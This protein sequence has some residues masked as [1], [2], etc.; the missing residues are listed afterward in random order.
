MAQTAVRGAYADTAIPDEILNEAATWLMEL[1]E[2]PLSPG[3]R[4]HLVQWRQRSPEHERA[5]EKASVLLEKFGTLPPSGIQALKQT[6]LPERRKAVKVL[7]A[8]MLAPAAWITY[9]AVPWLSHEGR[10]DTAVGERLDIV[11]GDGSNVSLNTNTQIDVS[12]SNTERVV[13]LR[14]GEIMITTAKDQARSPRPFLVAVNEGKIRALGTRFTVRQ[15]ERSSQVAVFEGAVEIT[16]R[17]CPSAGTVMP[18]GKQSMFSATQVGAAMPCDDAAAA[19]T[20]GMLIADR[21]PMSQF[22]AEL[23]RYRSGSLQYDAEVAQLAV[24]GVFPLADTGFTLSLLEQT[25]PV[26][27]QYFT[28]YWVRVLPR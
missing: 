17:D 2:G 7:A 22:I 23:S 11:L 18:A 21:M 27:I 13:Q 15:Q 4:M 16:P 6:A 12:F 25:M 14:R 26:R 5:W 3:Q 9:R 19:W 1:H 8:L 20:S 28:R 10:Y 24:S